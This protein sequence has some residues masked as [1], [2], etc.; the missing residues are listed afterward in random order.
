MKFDIDKI[1]LA[2]D[3][4]RGQFIPQYILEIYGE[5]IDPIP[6]DWEIEAIEN[7]PDDEDYW[8]AW[9]NIL[10]SVI[11]FTTYEGDEP[12]EYNL[13]YNEDLW[14]VPIDMVIPDDWYI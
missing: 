14:L 5:F 13:V 12:T 7:G 8:E 9:E 2:A 10:N 11:K 6:M 4:H 3:S 1:E